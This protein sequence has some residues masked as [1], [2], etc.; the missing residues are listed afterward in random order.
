MNMGLKNLGE[1]ER[2]NLSINIATLLRDSIVTGVFPP[3]THLNEVEMAQQ[4]GVSRGPLREALRILETEGLLESYPGRGTFVSQIS[5][6]EIQEV[7][8]LRCI[9]EE[10]AIKLA[11]ERGTNEDF[12]QLQATLD[13]MFKAAEANNTSEV[14][15]HDFRFHQQIW[16]L[17]DHR[18]L[19]DVLEG[20]T[21]QIRIYLAVQTQLYDDLAEGVSDHKHLL[22]ALRNHDGES[23]AKVMRDHLQLAANVVLEYYKKKS[24]A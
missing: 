24:G 8:S 18:L 7:Y 22:T 4:L 9:L 2:S 13:D 23:G 14:V 15:D 1:L 3:G 11:A 16:E 17:A 12:D 20:I 5:E 19:K 21:T 10:A 6:R